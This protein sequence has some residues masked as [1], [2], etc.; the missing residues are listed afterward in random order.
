MTLDGESNR[1]RRDRP[2]LRDRQPQ[3]VLHG[4]LAVAGCQLQDLQ[5]FAGRHARSVIAQ[6]PIVGDAKMARGKH[7]RVILIVLQ[8]AGLPH[9]RV[10]HVPVIDGVLAVADQPRHPLNETSRP[11]DFDL[12][13][14]DHH[15]DLHADQPA[16][17]RV[18]ITF[19]LNRAAAMHL[20]S[21]DALPVIELARRQLAQARLLLGEL[22]GPPRI[23]L[24]DQACQKPFVLFAAGKV[25]AAAQQ[26]RLI[27]GRFQMAVRRFDVAVLMRLADVDPLRL[28]L[29]VVHQV[30]VTLAKLAVL[31]EVVDRRA[32]AVAAMSPR[33]AVQLPHRLLESAAHRLERFREA[34]R[35]ELPIRVREREVIQHV[36]ERPAVDRDAQRVHVR[37]VRRPQPAGIMHLRKDDLLVGAVQAAPVAHPPLERSPLRVGESAG[38][39]LLQP[40]EQGERPQPRLPFESCLNLRPDLDKRVR[41]RSPVV[42]RPALRGQ[43]LGIA[44]LPSRLR[45]HAGSP[46]RQTETIAPRQQPPQFSHLPIR[47]H[48]NLH[49]NKELRLLPVCRKPGI[50][51]VAHRPTAHR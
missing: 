39:A 34:D 5:V 49:E 27:D 4:V 22:V 28:D 13:G 19:D 3:R 10:D 40:G 33:H 9:Q 46:R 38:I 6:Q 45:I 44:I 24:V 51:I 2:V 32:E 50:L 23:P 20:D 14:V 36:L 43:P 29:V 48:R 7:V 1:L 25:A 8:G 47:D 16:G 11:P 37:E 26:E 21:T 12:V 15:V 31:R 30:A 41:P 42:W 35:S 17:N 18:R